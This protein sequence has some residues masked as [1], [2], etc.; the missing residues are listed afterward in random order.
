MLI[1]L[2]NLFAVAEFLHALQV[3]NLFNKPLDL[4]V[5]AGGGIAALHVGQLTDPS[6]Q[7]LP[8]ST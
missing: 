1:T 4:R 8:V 3:P 6:D 5:V 2:G 7:I